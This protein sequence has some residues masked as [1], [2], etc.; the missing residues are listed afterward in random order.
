MIVKQG[1]GISLSNFHQFNRTEFQ[2][3]HVDNYRRVKIRLIGIG[4]GIG[5]PLAVFGPCCIFVSAP[6]LKR[7]KCKHEGLYFTMFYLEENQKLTGNDKKWK[8]LLPGSHFI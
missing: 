5:F 1:S 3:S 2:T 8:K 6:D 4:I 7:N